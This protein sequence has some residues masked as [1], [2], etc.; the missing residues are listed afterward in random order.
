VSAVAGRLRS[1]LRTLRARINDWTERR[2]AEPREVTVVARNRIYILPTRFG[3]GFAATAFVML[4]GALNYSNSMAF[5]LTFLL[6][7]LGL[8][9]MHHTHANLAQLR[10]ISAQGD[11]VFAGESAQLTLVLDNPARMA[12]WSLVLGFRNLPPELPQDVPAAGR[13]TVRV[14][15]PTRQRGW[16]RPGVVEL[17]TEFPLG[18]FHAWTLFRPASRVLVYPSPAPPGSPPPT[19]VSQSAPEGRVHAGNDEFAG[20][21]PY[22]PGD[23]L[24]AIH[25]KSLPRTG[26]PMVKQFV[27]HR[28]HSQWLDWEAAAGD[29]EARLSQLTRWVIDAE[30]AG[31]PYGLRLP[32]RAFGPSNGPAHREACLEALALFGLADPGAP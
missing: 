25:W 27:D 26:R 15:L 13:S 31:L 1:P 8:V 20:L 12:R 5:A 19:A 30:T 10:L 2:V 29:T 21:R 28:E 17:S 3:W 22:Q 18:L 9:C 23:T 14:N 4:L 7:G 11:A 6:A 16:L 24:R 32:N